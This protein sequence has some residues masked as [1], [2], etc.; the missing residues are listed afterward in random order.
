VKSFPA[1]SVSLAGHR[2]DKVIAKSTRDS[3]QELNALGFAELLRHA[4]QV[5]DFEKL[6][7]G[8]GSRA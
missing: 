7:T 3:N 6:V 8:E 4:W 5:F 2:T 1:H